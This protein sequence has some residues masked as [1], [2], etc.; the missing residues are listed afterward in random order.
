MAD[1]LGD[2]KEHVRSVLE[3]RLGIQELKTTK[4]GFC[5]RLMSSELCFMLHETRPGRVVIF[6]RGFVARDVPLS[7][8]L[9]EHVALHGG[10]WLYGH[11]TVYPHES[12]AA[13]NV[14]LNHPLAA[15]H[16]TDEL[17]IEATVMLGRTLE[18]IDDQIVAAFG[19]RMQYKVG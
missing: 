15:E 19:G 3:A 18:E 4:S 12:G 5:F 9:Y 2:V 14:I 13:G 7:A 8:A 16:T 11:L 17:L 6:I 1:N 10:D